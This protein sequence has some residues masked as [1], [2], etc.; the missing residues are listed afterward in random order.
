MLFVGTC[1]LLIHH[2][3]LHHVM[4]VCYVV[5]HHHHFNSANSDDLLQGRNAQ[6]RRSSLYHVEAD[7]CTSDC[8]AISPCV[9]EYQEKLLEVYASTEGQGGQKWPGRKTDKAIP[10]NLA[11]IENEK[12]YRSTADA[13]TQPTLHG[14]IDEIDKSKK[15]ITKE[16]LFRGDKRCIVVQGAAGI[17]KSTFGFELAQDWAQG[18]AGLKQFKLVNLVQLRLP[19]THS[20]TSIRDFLHP[21]PSQEL[22]DE[23]EFTKGE[24]V[25]LILDGFDELP[26]S[27]QDRASV[28]GRLIQGK[29]LPKA[30]ILITSRPTAAKQLERLSPPEQTLHVEILGFQLQN[31]QAYVSDIFSA[32]P[33]LQQAFLKY[34]SSNLVIRNMMYIP[35]HTA[36]VVELFR[37]KNAARRPGTETSYD[38][39]L[40]EL[41]KDLC[42]CLLYRYMDSKPLDDLP[43]FDQLK[44]NSLPESIQ[45]NFAS[46]SSHAYS[47]LLQQE[48][49]FDSLPADFDHMGFMRTVAFQSNV[50]FAPPSHSYSFLHLTLQEFLVALHLYQTQPASRHLSMIQQ[51]PKDHRNIVLRFLAGLSQFKE[52]GWTCVR[53]SMG[54]MPDSQGNAGCN[55][56]LLNC[57]FEAQDP[58]A[59]EEVFPGDSTVNYSPMTATQFDY[60]ALG[61]CIATSGQKCKWKLCAI[62]GEGLSAIAAGLCSVAADPHG[63]I[64]MIKLSYGGDKIHNLAKL[65]TSILEELRELNL[66][67]CGLN[68]EACNWLARFICKD[69]LLLLRQ[70]DLS[71]NPFSAGG[72][73][74]LLQSLSLLNDFQ[75]LDLLHAQLG[76][77]DLQSM[78]HLIRKNGTLKNLIIGD[79]AMTPDIVEHMVDVVLA[80]SSLENISFMNIDFPRLA[81]HLAHRLKCNT[82]LKSVMLWDRSF[83]TSGA[84]EIL[85]ALSENETLGV[86]TLMP[87][88]RG[89]IPSQVLSLPEVQN[90]IQWFIYPERKK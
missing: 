8:A 68:N 29:Y 13:F 73:C 22:V 90:R 67:N 18:T 83:C 85:N 84:V 78:K 48:L 52:I 37:M 11:M 64:E 58:E 66:S 72:A 21:E 54:I 71:D 20:V 87:W 46:L 24:G 82:T 4:C 45:S 1:L 79:R 53:E 27:M 69:S 56:T 32:E 19:T 17:G 5:L 41:F 15:P 30:R 6:H 80:D 25:L 81:A 76:E 3:H 63:R 31:I 14:N 55:S 47:S 65:P 70:L 12:A 89:N 35:L 10:T 9:L 36:I 38:V 49:I 88:Y 74:K 16:C 62:G 33:E 28:Y 60:F 44:L 59:S 26:K 61:Y 2:A 75:Y 34:I 39:T 40:T 77:E 23:I 43:S 57:L 51:I 50:P 42:R 7:K 86:V